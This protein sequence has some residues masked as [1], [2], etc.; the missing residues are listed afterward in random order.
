MEHPWLIHHVTRSV[1][2]SWQG[3]RHTEE[4]PSFPAAPHCVLLFN[5]IT[6][7]WRQV[8]SGKTF[9]LFVFHEA[10]TNL[11]LFFAL[12]RVL[13]TIPLLSLPSR[14]LYDSTAAYSNKVGFLLHIPTRG[15]A[16][17]RIWSANECWMSTIQRWNNSHKKLNSM[18]DSGSLLYPPLDPLNANGKVNTKRP[19]MAHSSPIQFNLLSISFSRT[20]FST[21]TTSTK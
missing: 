1:V 11:L 2:C 9:H 13:T 8:W 10:S 4:D 15:R 3:Q 16:H 12:L 19:L 5:R 14:I 17:N 21:R 20:T 6:K 7:Q 18:E